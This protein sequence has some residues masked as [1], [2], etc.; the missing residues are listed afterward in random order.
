MLA[1][2]QPRYPVLVSSTPVPAP[3]RP[4][5]G[6]DRLAPAHRT[7]KDGFRTIIED[8]LRSTGLL[9]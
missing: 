9:R 7:N 3:A 8:A 5:A 2:G 6:G 4:T 1:T